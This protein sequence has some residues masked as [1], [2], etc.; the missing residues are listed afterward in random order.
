MIQCGKKRKIKSFRIFRSRCRPCGCGFSI[1]VSL[2]DIIIVYHLAKLIVAI[3]QIVQSRKSNFPYFLDPA[4]VALCL[5][6]HLFALLTHIKV[7]DVFLALGFYLV[8]EEI[9]NCFRSLYVCP[10]FKGS[11]NL[12]ITNLDVL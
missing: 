2:I 8:F 11:E 12:I 10:R 9:S 4:V 3:A 1:F 7:S 5:F 6:V